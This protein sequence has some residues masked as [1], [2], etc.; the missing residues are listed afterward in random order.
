VQR[1]A[2]IALEIGPHREGDIQMRIAHVI[3]VAALASL[4]IAIAPALAKSSDNQKTD[5]K[6]TSPICHAYQQ[7]ADGSWK[8]L[9][10][11]EATPPSQASHKH[12]F[13]NSGNPA[14]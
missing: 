12:A 7:A 9:P 11:A 3:F 4:A 10:C 13:R 2:Q 8:D 1:F 14:R 6:L 5:D